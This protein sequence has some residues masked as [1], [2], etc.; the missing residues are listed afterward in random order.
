MVS[1]SVSEHFLNSRK[2]A[3]VKSQ[4]DTQTIREQINVV[5]TNE[6]SLSDSYLNSMTKERQIILIVFLLRVEE[7]VLTTV[8]LWVN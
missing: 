8:E 7:V 6:H 2:V 4:C 1:F 3:K 5:N